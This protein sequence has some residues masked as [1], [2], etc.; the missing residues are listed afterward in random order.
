M[1][2]IW[3]IIYLHLCVVTF[4]TFGQLSC[5]GVYLKFCSH[6]RL[7]KTNSLD[8]QIAQVSHKF[9]K[10]KLTIELELLQWQ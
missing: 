7:L 5:A 8:F 1:M 2:N 4:L 10:Y 9:P 3:V 6:E